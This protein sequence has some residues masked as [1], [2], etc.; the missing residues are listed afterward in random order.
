M[1]TWMTEKDRF[2]MVDVRNVKGIFLKG[3]LQK[4]AAMDAGQGLC[5]VQT[6]E[7]KPLYSAMEAMGYSYETEKISD[8]EYR[9]YFY[10]E[11]V[12]PMA[13]KGGDM[14]FKPTALLNFKKIDNALAGI[15]VDF[16][17]LTWER[18]NPAIDLKTKLLLS[19]SNAVG[20]GRSRQ[21]ARELIKAYAIGMTVPE[22]DELFELFAWNQGI[23]NFASEIGPS[24]LFKIYQLIKGREQAGKTREDIMPELMEKF[25]PSNPEVEV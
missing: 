9:A 18:E 5:V 13:F 17:E 16:W 12:T 1:K 22:M 24:P 23:G 8:D 4:A 3:L 25:G 19:L 15:A 2:E 21:A 10:R 7:P 11:S 6:F 20:A 14:P